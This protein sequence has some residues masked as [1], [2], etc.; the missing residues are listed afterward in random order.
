MILTFFAISAAASE[1]DASAGVAPEEALKLLREGNERFVQEK[2]EH[3]NSLLD[4]VHETAEHGQH[5]FVTILSCSDSRV[6]LETIFD[7]GIGDIFVIRVAGNVSGDGQLGSIEY[8]VA[9]TGTRL[10]VVLGHTKCGAITAACTDGGH[11]GKVEHLM[12]AI[13]PAVKRT[14]AKT[15]K[16]G[17]DAVPDCCKENVYL[18]IESLYRDSKIL[19]DA[20]SN[21]NLV[22]VGAIYDIDTGKVEFLGQHPDADSLLKTKPIRYIKPNRLERMFS[23]GRFSR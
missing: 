7:Q 4:R 13:A 17:I 23:T 6:P 22:I 15:G 21:G 10:C 2:A 16:K 9:H 12:K 11:E 3:P 19:R 8:G 20:V 14:E 18:Q 5:P 1:H